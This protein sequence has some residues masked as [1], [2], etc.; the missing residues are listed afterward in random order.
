AQ[1]PRHTAR[2]TTAGRPQADMRNFGESRITFRQ[3]AHLG[4]LPGVKK[5]SW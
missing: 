1:P 5:P 4:Q 3:L 2:H